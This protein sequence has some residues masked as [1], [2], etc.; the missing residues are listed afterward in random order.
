MRENR[1][2]NHAVDP[3]KGG[4][5]NASNPSIEE[6]AEGRTGASFLDEKAE[7][8]I[9]EAGNIEDMHDERDEQEREKADGD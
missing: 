8:Y 7:T 4:T 3:F 1:N 6:A 9:R 5:G 2:N